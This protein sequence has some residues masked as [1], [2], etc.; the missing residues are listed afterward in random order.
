MGKPIVRV[1][2]VTAHGGIVSMGASTVFAGGQP[3]ARIGDLHSCPIPIH[4]GGGP[5]LGPGIPT[6]IVEGKPVVVV[7]DAALCTGPPDT[8]V[9]G[10]PTVI[11][12][13]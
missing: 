3:V 8:L 2:D 10:C 6:I 5:I 11:A 12:G 1:G 13:A 9:G 4:A 7:G